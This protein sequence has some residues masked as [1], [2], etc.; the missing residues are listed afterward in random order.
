MDVVAQGLHVTVLVSNLKTKDVLVNFDESV[1]LV[2]REVEVME[3]LGLDVPVSAIGLKSKQ[4]VFKQ[5]LN[6]LR[7][8][9]CVY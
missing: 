1:L 7:V 4:A 9:Y 8:F 2:I 3:K 6:Q 5:E